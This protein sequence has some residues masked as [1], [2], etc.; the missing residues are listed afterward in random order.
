VKVG[1]GRERGVGDK[2][3]IEGFHNL[4]YTRLS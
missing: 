3:I 1:N 4:Y 2:L